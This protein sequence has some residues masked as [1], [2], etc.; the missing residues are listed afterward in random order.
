MTLLTI[1]G[2]IWSGAPS[3]L[4]G[5]ADGYALDATGK[6][7]ALIIAIERTGTIEAVEF[8]PGTD[9]AINAASVVRVSFQNI[10]NAGLPDGTQDQYRDMLGS[11]LSSA[12]WKDSGLITHNGTDGGTKRAVTI[13]DFI[14]IVFE[15]QTFTASDVVS[16]REVDPVTGL[17]GAPTA[18]PVADGPYPGIHDGASW[19][20]TVV[21]RNPMTLA[22]R[23]DDGTYAYLGPGV[24]PV[25]TSNPI[26][27]NDGF[28]SEDEVGVAFKVPG[29]VTIDGARV[30]MAQAGGGVDWQIRL[31]DAADSLLGQST[32]IPAAAWG[33]G[34]GVLVGAHVPLTTTV[35]LLANDLYRATIRSLSGAISTVYNTLGRVGVDTIGHLDAYGGGRNFYST[36]RS[37]GGIWTDEL[38][39]HPN[40]DLS[41][42]R[43]D[44][45]VVSGGS[46]GGAPG[47][48]FFRGGVS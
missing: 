47:R 2:G 6:R 12:L 16:I 28:L 37:N 15:Y 14:A 17:S 8:K 32:I 22:L 42:S 41:F 7:V 25:D 21:L 39:L 38:T 13:G 20:V 3:L 33:A 29:S 48:G 9:L 26:N 11:S 19:D 43:I 40:I 27:F 1:P 31:Y 46:G 45:G 30:L 24:V 5:S 4:Q 18:M 44:D 36:R 34:A 35:D 23:Y 10:D